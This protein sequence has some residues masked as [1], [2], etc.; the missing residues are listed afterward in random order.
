MLSDEEVAQL[1]A[2]NGLRQFDVA[3]GM[4]EYFLDPQRPFALRPSL[5]QDLQKVAVQ[6][7]ESDPGTYRRGPIEISKSAHK[8][9]PAHLVS[10]RV[11][12]MC[13]YINDSWHEKSAFHL[14]SYVMWRLNWI[15][16]FSDGNGRTSRMCSYVVLCVKVGQALP[17]TPTIPEQIAAD[18]TLYFKALEA[19]DQAELAGEPDL[20]EMEAMLKAMLAN[21]LLHVIERAEGKKVE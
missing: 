4:I 18:R 8:P 13:D 5:I 17:G 15:H 10:A 20:S 16:P 6:G 2:E 11:Q 1:E 7:I 21:Q 19:A 12:E 3:I 9:P 14:A